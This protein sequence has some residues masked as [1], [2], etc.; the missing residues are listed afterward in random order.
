MYGEPEPQLIPARDTATGAVA[1]AE[2]VWQ[3]SDGAFDQD[4]EEL[5]P[6]AP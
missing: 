3:G 2:V 5:M 6:E 1:E 4:L